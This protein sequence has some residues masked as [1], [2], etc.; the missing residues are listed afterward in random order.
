MIG[1]SI[2][3]QVTLYRRARVGDVD[4]LVT[5]VH[6]AQLDGRHHVEHGTRRVV[7]QAQAGHV[8]EIFRPDWPECLSK[9]PP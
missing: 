3:G 1:A 9:G 6:V 2:S 5:P 4:G 7:A 8:V